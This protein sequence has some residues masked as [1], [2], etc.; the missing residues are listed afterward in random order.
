MAYKYNGLSIST[1]SSSPSYM[2]AQKQHLA[3]LRSKAKK[4][5]DKTSWVEY[6]E[7]LI[8][9]IREASKKKDYHKVKK[10]IEELNR[11]SA[12]WLIRFDK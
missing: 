1:I 11:L 10:K 12:V 7:L 4:Y 2:L 3:R 9:E 6:S 5:P 8:Y